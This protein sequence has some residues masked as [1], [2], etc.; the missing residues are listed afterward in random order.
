MG[1]QHVRVYSDLPNARVVGVMDIDPMVSRAV[2]EE[3]SVRAAGSI[4]ELLEIGLDAASVCVT[5]SAHVTVARKLVSRGVAVLVE[6]PLAS[7]LAEGRALV[8]DARATG[9]PLMVGHVER[10]NPAVANVRAAIQSDEV[11]SIEIS[12]V[13]PF[14]PRIRDVG[15]L[16]DLAAHDIDLVHFITGAEYEDVYAMQAGPAHQEDTVLILARMSNRVLAQLTT[17]WVTPYKFREIRVATR[18]RYLRADLITQLTM[19]FSRYSG[20]GPMYQVREWPMLYREPLR[21]ELMA[22]VRAVSRGDEVPVPGEDGLYVL[23]V[24]ERI[25][26]TFHGVSE[27]TQRLARQPI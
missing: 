10:F 20:T 14:P 21:E 13:G 18:A 8:A 4:D 7:S 19:E 15:V 2:S 23:E 5:T 6:K 9:A 25:R 24:I 26:S 27:R 17:N 22:F 11:V 12:R 16:I 3:F 1:R